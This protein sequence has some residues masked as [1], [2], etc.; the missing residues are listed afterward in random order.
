MINDDKDPWPEPAGPDPDDQS[1]PWLTPANHAW[2]WDE[3]SL[4]LGEYVGFEPYLRLR[5]RM[6]E[7]QIPE[8]T[9]NL[10]IETLI[11]T[12][13]VN[14]MN[15]GVACVTLITQD[16]DGLIDDVHI[17]NPDEPGGAPMQQPSE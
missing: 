9:H 2:S 10:L 14:Y 16:Q 7:L 8:H 11:D 1:N 12:H 3:E 15:H 5:D 17:V 6:C 4:N 13:D